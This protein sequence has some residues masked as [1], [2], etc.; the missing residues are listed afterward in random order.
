MGSLLEGEFH[1]GYSD[2]LVVSEPT[3]HALDF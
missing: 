3:L 2:V 1:D